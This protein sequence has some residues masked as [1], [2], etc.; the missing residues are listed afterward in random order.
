MEPE[1]LRVGIG[2]DIHPLA[3]GRDLVLG[4]VRIDYIKGLSGH[5]DAD[6][7]TH[8]LCDALLGALN[9]GDIGRHF[10]ETEEYRNVSSIVLLEKVGR[11]VSDSGYRL[12]NADCIIIAEAPHLADMTSAMSEKISGALGTDPGRVSVKC[13]RGEGMGPVGEKRA[14]EARA[15][16]LLA[17][18]G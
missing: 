18:A 14:M 11:M 6:V 2:Y 13:T 3:S 15:V 16:V 8:A 7:L 10:P 12:V 1:Q 5:S 4:G 17:S 9:R